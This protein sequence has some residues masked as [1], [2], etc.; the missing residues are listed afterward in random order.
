M[1]RFIVTTGLLF[2]IAPFDIYNLSAQTNTPP[3][4]PARLP[5]S[6]LKRHDFFYAGEGKQEQMFIVR[7]DKVAQSYVYNGRGEISD[8]TLMSG[9]DILFAHQFGVTEIS[10]DRR[11]VWNYDAPTNTE[12]HTAQPIGTNRVWFIEN[13]NPAKLV[14]MNKA[15]GTVE[16]EFVLPVGN[17]KGTHGQFRHARLT[18][19]G[20]LLVAHMDL[21]R[22]CEYDA[23]GKELWSIKVP[24][25]WSVAPLKN[26]NILTAGRQGVAELNRRGEPVWQWTPSDT[27]AYKMSNVQQATRLPNGNTL[28]NNWFN[29]WSG[30][31]D[32]TNAPVQ[33][34]EI[35]RRKKVVWALRSWNDPNLGP[36]TTIQ[37]LDKK[38]VP[39]NVRFGEFR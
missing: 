36:S 35:T 16:R 21:G 23:T 33:A 10:A 37:L 12:I 31:L 22:V 15:T 1:N 2:A 18:D 25:I 13:G 28:I 34:I 30:K 6:G 17:P 7:G 32:P 8:A 38:S 4:A 11:V 24:G 26:G 29:E 14:V 9:G 20:T 39:E 3:L 19:A 27:P 5:G